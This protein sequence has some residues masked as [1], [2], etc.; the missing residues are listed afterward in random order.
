MTNTVENSESWTSDA[1][2]LAATSIHKTSRIPVRLPQSSGGYHSTFFIR[3][4]LKPPS[5]SSNQQGVN[6]D[7]HRRCAARFC[8][9][10][11]VGSQ[12]RAWAKK[13]LSSDDTVLSAVLAVQLKTVFAVYGGKVGMDE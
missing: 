5:P 12:R 4:S 2:D 1:F 3:S 10:C 8:S 13:P 7:T 11:A 9:R 6:D